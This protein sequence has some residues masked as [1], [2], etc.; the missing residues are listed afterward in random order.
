MLAPE[1]TQRG[2]ITRVGGW[3]FKGHGSLSNAASLVSESSGLYPS[4]PDRI[5]TTRDSRVA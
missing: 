5:I 2:F 4:Y 1:V 3:G